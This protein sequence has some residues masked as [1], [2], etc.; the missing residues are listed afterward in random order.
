MVTRYPIIR[1]LGRQ[2]TECSEGLWFTLPESFSTLPHAVQWPE[3]TTPAG[4][5]HPGFPQGSATKEL[6]AERVGR[7]E[8]IYSVVCLPI[9]S[10]VFLP[11]WHL[12]QDLFF[13]TGIPSTSTPS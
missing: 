8:C 5:F 11:E 3:Q 4:A 9:L 1:S 13:V 6:Q 10:E 2:L 7:E 12:H